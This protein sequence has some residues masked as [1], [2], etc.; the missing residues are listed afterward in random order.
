MKSILIECTKIEQ[1]NNI[2]CIL[3]LFQHKYFTYKTIIIYN[4]L[5]YGFKKNGKQWN[6]GLTFVVNIP[7]SW[8]TN[9][10]W[11]KKNIILFLPIETLKKKMEIYVHSTRMPLSY[12]KQVF[13]GKSLDE[14]SGKV[15]NQTYLW[16]MTLCVNFKWHA[17]GEL[18]L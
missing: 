16:S 17:L 13:F 5:L 2:V 12:S 11:K 9:K 7:I 10:I 4:T 18:V 15:Q 14:K 8:Y 3:C 6:N 1:K